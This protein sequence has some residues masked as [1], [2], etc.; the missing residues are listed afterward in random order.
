MVTVS[1]QEFEDFINDAMATLPKTHMDAVRNVAIV[2]ADEP[3]PQQRYELRL[4]NDQT[5]FGL[6]QGVPLSRRQGVT[7][8]PPDKITI[9]K[10]PI[11]RRANS[12]GELKEEVRHTLWHEIAHYFGLDHDKIHEL[13]R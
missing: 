8:Y 1:D 11:S 7:N 10:G 2:Y 9:F 13:E 5:L 6:Y 4:R 3:T 12:I